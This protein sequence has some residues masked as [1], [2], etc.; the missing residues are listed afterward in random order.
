MPQ[1][2]LRDHPG[3]P[4]TRASGRPRSGRRIPTSCIHISTQPV[5]FFVVTGFVS[6]LLP[7]LQTLTPEPSGPRRGSQPYEE[8]DDSNE[9]QPSPFGPILG[10]KDRLREPE[11]G[12]TPRPTIVPLPGEMLERMVLS[13]MDEEDT[14]KSVSA[15]VAFDL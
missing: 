9:V 14:T 10:I 4:S 5:H 12:D 1:T 3:E 15:L 2:S 13:D 8:E 11:I 6:C 7:F